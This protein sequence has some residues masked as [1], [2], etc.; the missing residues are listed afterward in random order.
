L[1]NILSKFHLSIY[2][3][4]DGGSAEK[5][6]AVKKLLNQ[7]IKQAIPNEGIYLD[8]GCAEGFGC[9]IIGKDFSFVINLDILKKNLMRCKKDCKNK[10]K[11]HLIVA[12]AIHLPFRNNVIKFVSAISVIE[13][14]REQAVFLREVSRILKH[15]GFYLMQFPNLNFIIE[16]HSGMPFPALIPNKIKIIYFRKVINI[17]D[18]EDLPLNLDSKKAYA[19][20][21]PLFNSIVISKCNYNKECVP[22]NLRVIYSFFKRLYFLE[23]CPMGYVFVCRK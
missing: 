22:K 9:E 13:H 17:D 2:E 18:H 14:L 8:I 20:C 12:D 11:T 7:V 19:L 6:E 10:N 15:R 16:M 5:F 23:V 21:R 3:S 4:Q 1:S